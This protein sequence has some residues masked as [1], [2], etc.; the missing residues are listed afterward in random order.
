MK[1]ALLDIQCGTLEQ[2]QLFMSAP[3]HFLTSQI[4]FDII[5]PNEA[6]YMSIQKKPKKKMKRV[7][8]KKEKDNKKKGQGKK[9]RKRRRRRTKKKMKKTKK[10]KERL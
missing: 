5:A 8:S 3:G 10:K 6:K 4:C 1:S 7:M 2:K 9:N